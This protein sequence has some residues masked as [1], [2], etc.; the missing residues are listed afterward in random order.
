MRPSET[1]RNFFGIWLT[2]LTLHG[3]EAQI[4]EQIDALTRRVEAFEKVSDA[5]QGTL[6]LKNVGTVLSVGGRIDL[7]AIYGWPEGSYF[8]GKIPLPST[9]E[10]GQ[11]MMS[12]RDSRLW[13]KTRT[14]GRF[15]PVRALIETDFQGVAGTETVTNSHG[16]R[17]RHAY[18]EAAGFAAGQANSA[19]NASTTPD[20]ITYA[21]NYTLVR[22][23]LI[24][25]G[26]EGRSYVVDCSFEQP[27]TT[28]RD[29]DGT[30]ITPKDDRFP[31]LVTRLRLFLVRGDLSL[32]LMGR[33]LTQDHA[34][35]GNG[36]VLDTRCAVPAWGANLSGKIRLDGL[37]DLRF[38]VQY[39]HGLGRY[40][41]FG[42]FADGVI[43][44]HD[45]GA[46]G[47]RR[48]SSPAPRLE[49]G[50]ALH[51]RRRVCRC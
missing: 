42:A 41:A 36:T 40:L 8:A 39:G 11:L 7:R 51:R 20:T 19:F 23:P 16:L 21:V 12:T 9:G 14:P 48:R 6:E 44:R 24:R 2:A 18:V 34:T 47:L 30:V 45:H 27:E 31:D 29:P 1:V 35:L 3:S 4:Q 15:G 43:D 32:S 28:L 26:Y 49:C 22:Q 25:Y 50:A 38:S 33:Y 13:V 37:D 46:T 10:Q 5:W 17:L